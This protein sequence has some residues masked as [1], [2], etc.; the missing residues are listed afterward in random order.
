MHIFEDDRAV[1]SSG[2]GDEKATFREVYV[3]A[4]M[5]S[6]RIAKGLREKMADS[7][8]FASDFAKVSLLANVGRIN[9]TMTCAHLFP[10]CDCANSNLWCV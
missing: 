2:F 6:P 9:T 1:F 8:A 3:R 4:L 10:Y 5:A 7:P